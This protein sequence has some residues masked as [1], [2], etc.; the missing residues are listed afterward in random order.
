MNP[1]IRWPIVFVNGIA[2]I[3]FWYFASTVLAS[4]SSLALR[5]TP[6]SIES[7]ESDSLPT[8]YVE[9]SGG[10]LVPL[11]TYAGNPPIPT[12]VVGA[13][14]TSEIPLKKWKALDPA[15]QQSEPPSNSLPVHLDEKQIERLWP[16]LKD[17]TI[18]P[19]PPEE[20]APIPIAITGESVSFSGEVVRPEMKGIPIRYLVYEEHPLRKLSFYVFMGVF[21]TSFACFYAFFVKPPQAPAPSL[22]VSTPEHTQEHVPV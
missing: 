10:V 16:I 8:G 19:Y 5:P 20:L 15:R 9:I 12:N 17:D 21:S 22:P 4:G 13:Y 7:V 18:W 11:I 6:V 2:A 1:A 14:L 3:G